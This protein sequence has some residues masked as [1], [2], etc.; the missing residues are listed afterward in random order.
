[1]ASAS[2]VRVFAAVVAVL[3]VGALA[4]AAS[5]ARE[6]RVKAFREQAKGEREKL[7]LDAKAVRGQYPTPEIKLGRAITLRPGAT[8]PVEVS[9]AFQK[10]SLFVVEADD[11]EVVREDLGAGGW[12]AQLAVRK[13]ALP[14]TV[15]LA[16]YSPVSAIP[17]ST[18]AF[19][20]AG[21]YECQVQLKRGL[22]ARLVA[23]A[24]DPLRYDVTWTRPPATAPLRSSVAKMDVQYG[25]IAFEIQGDQAEI[26][27]AMQR[28]QKPGGAQAEM[29]AE[30]Q[31]CDKL[32]QAEMIKCFQAAGE[33]IKTI[34][35]KEA[36]DSVAGGPACGH[37]DVSR[38]RVTGELEGG[39][40]RSCM[41]SYEDRVAKASCTPIE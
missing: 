16:V 6:Q 12:K 30:M 21:R 24:G 13:G 26:M 37:L 14:Q 41:S 34:Q 32:A 40:F 33:R 29:M 23:Q 22:A 10:G 27:A 20:V 35:A 31:K 7:K 39:S 8:T 36:E 25:G 11:V 38:N 17:A 4:R 18:N 28:S 2:T 1:M 19:V 15:R 9:G 5:D 3:A